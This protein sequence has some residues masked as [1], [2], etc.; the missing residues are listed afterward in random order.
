MAQVVLDRGETEL[1]VIQDMGYAPYFL[2]VSD[3]IAYAR[4]NGVAVGP[5][6]GSAAGSIV[7]YALGITT[8]DPL[9]HGL[10]FERFLNRARISMPDIDVD[11]DDRNRDRVIEYVGQ[12]Y[13]Q[14]H[15]PQIITFGTM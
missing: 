5:G 1:S 11:F 7:C 9:Q 10:S 15:V 14:E 8:L 2:I 12:K 4:A 6:R 13:G 3:F